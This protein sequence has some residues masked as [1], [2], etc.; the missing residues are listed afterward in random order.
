M[1]ASPW[2][3]PIV[4]SAALTALII[5]AGPVVITVGHYDY[6]GSKRKKGI[7]PCFVSHSAQSVFHM[8]T[9]LLK[10]RSQLQPETIQFVFEKIILVIL[11]LRS[12]LKY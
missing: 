2:Q 8:Q 12:L 3:L 9:K 11:P 10:W 5:M 7:V 1:T 4:C 6:K